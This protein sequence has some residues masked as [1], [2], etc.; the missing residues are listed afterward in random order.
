[1]KKFAGLVL[2]GYA[3]FN[4]FTANAQTYAESALIFSRIKPGGS[5]RIQALGGAQVSLGGD[6][7]SGYSNPA[8]LGMY[9]RSE[10]TFTPGYNTAAMSS[11]YLGTSTGSSQSKLIVPG[12]SFVFH[13]DK[14]KGA[15]ISGTFGITFNRINDFNR[16]FE[17][18]GVN[19][20]NSIIDYF[21]GD[22]NFSNYSGTGSLI[23]R[24]R[25]PAQLFNKGG[26][27]YNTPTELAWDNYLINT[28]SATDQTHYATDFIG[29]P[30][31]HEKVQVSGAQNQWS[32]SYGVNLSDKVFLGGGIGVTSINYTS[33]KTYTESFPSDTLLSSL[34]LVENLR[35]RGSGFNAT[36]GAIY[37]P[38]DIFQFG[39]SV[40]T[41]TAYMLSDTYNAN[42]GTNWIKFPYGAANQPKGPIQTDDVL[43][44]YYLTTPWRL[45]GGATFFIQ[46]HGLVS[47]DVEYLNYGG[48]HYSTQ[49]KGVSFSS[50]NA[51]IKSA[52]HS[53]F[54]YR[55]GA[56]YRLNAFRIR[57]GYSYMPDP[58]KSVQNNVY[59]DLQSFS[60]GVGYRASKF[61]VDLT[62]VFTQG[63]TT[64]RPYTFSPLVKN[65]NK[66][67]LIMATVGFP[68]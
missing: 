46:K 17:Y 49:T 51:D 53:V 6:Y 24:N 48:N 55:L 9:N 34:T 26:D 30:T 13:S 61:F 54:N 15:L 57:A 68:F 36:L 44:D 37:K 4:S 40:A 1:M 47:A 18:G 10:F 12:L 2:V 11:D 45:S 33:K 5:A 29:I 64:Y 25:T 65:Q 20:N 39:V 56:E 28:V 38:M 14:N 22:A 3:L 62:G 19:S 66:N 42:M 8:G 67:T 63:S 21:V 52:Y 27:L 7:S 32:F 60:G 23:A 59:N 41:P 50:D 58:Y 31:Q 16:T 35:T 43:T